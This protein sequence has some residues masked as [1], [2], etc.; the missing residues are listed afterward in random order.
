ME[1]NHNMLRGIS[2]NGGIVFYGVDSTEMV[3]ERPSRC[4]L[5]LRSA[6]MSVQ[7]NCAIISILTPRKPLQNFPTGSQ[8][9]LTGG[10][11]SLT[12]YPSAYIF[13]RMRR[14]GRDSP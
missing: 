7:K 5:K 4:I 10:N 13:H 9:S 2:E 11:G 12:K 8:R 14:L 1:Q 3:R 6:T